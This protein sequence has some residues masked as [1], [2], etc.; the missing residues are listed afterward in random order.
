MKVLLRLATA[1]ESDPLLRSNALRELGLFPESEE[2]VAHLL[3]VAVDKTALRTDRVGAINGLSCPHVLNKARIPGL[4][5]LLEDT[6]SMIQ[7]AAVRLLA[8]W[9]EAQP[10]IIELVADPETNIDVQRL[11]K[12]GLKQ[13]Q[14]RSPPE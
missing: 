5:S 6:D 3:E 8:R 10:R 4:L 1:A 13:A 14:R 9:P 2:A 7:A 11:G 12:L